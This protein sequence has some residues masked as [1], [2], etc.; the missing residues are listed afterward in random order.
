MEED[1]FWPHVLDGLICDIKFNLATT[2]EISTS[3]ISDC[4]ITHPNQ[5][6]NPFL[7]LPVESG[8]CESCGAAELGKCEENKKR[9]KSRKKTPNMSVP[10]SKHPKA[11]TPI[12]HLR[13]KEDDDPRSKKSNYRPSI[14]HV[15]PFM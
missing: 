15:D 6:T 12:H 7:G 14:F 13:T 4:S 11:Y 10:K 8:K 9:G 5:L 1:L 2:E 3:S